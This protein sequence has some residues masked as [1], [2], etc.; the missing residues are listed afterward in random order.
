V[1][2]ASCLAG[3]IDSRGGGGK[4]AKKKEKK[5]KEQKGAPPTTFDDRAAFAPRVIRK[6]VHDWGWKKRGGKPFIRRKERK[7]G[8]GIFLASWDHALHKTSSSMGPR[9]RWGNF[10]EGKRREEKRGRVGSIPARVAAR[11]KLLGKE[12]KGMIS[13]FNI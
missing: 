13:V 3:R 7:R 10:G 8:D 1:G 6:K 4:R 9:G 11:K 2:D 12:R 5:K